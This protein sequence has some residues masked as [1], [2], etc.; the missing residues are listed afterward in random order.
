MNVLISFAPASASHPPPNKRRR[1]AASSG[2]SNGCE[3]NNSAIADWF[4]ALVVAWSTYEGAWCFDGD[5]LDEL[6][7][8]FQNS[9]HMPMKALVAVTERCAGFGS[10]R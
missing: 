6:D 3:A 1:P 5:T 8:S 9:N 2:Q 4:T 7:Q 10:L